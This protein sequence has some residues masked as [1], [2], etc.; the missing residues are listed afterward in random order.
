MNLV[1]VNLVDANMGVV[2]ADTQES[3]LHTSNELLKM[4]IQKGKDERAG[5]PEPDLMARCR[6]HS[7]EDGQP[8]Y[9]DK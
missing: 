3:L 8:C 1:D 5:V 7:H 2:N 6:Y 9:L 4:F